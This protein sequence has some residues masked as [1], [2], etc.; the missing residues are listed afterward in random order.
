MSDSTTD[1]GDDSEDSGLVSLSNDFLEFIQDFCGFGGF[2]ETGWEFSGGQFKSELVCEFGTGQGSVLASADVNMTVRGV[3]KA[4]EGL[5]F[6]EVEWDVRAGVRDGDGVEFLKAGLGGFGEFLAGFR[7]LQ[8][9]VALLNWIGSNGD[10][11]N[12][13][14]DH[15][16]G[17]HD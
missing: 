14:G 10:C 2:G 6:V 1:F 5:E 8:A 4:E 16:E 15:N 7:R 13:E 12:S 17:L 3:A 11:E 9:N